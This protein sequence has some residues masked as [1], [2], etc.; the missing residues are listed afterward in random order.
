MDHN[1]GT[2]RFNIID[3]TRR[4]TAAGQ[5]DRVFDVYV[6]DNNQRASESYPPG[7]VVIVAT[8][9]FRSGSRRSLICGTLW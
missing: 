6:S 9:C 7:G 8:S 1:V 2:G 3:F 5:I 4:A